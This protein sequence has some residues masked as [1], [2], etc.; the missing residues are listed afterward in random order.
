M[1]TVGIGLALMGLLALVSWTV[2]T[3]TFAQGIPSS[4]LPLS[5]QTTTTAAQEGPGNPLPLSA[6]TIPC[7]MNLPEGDIDGETI[8]CGQIEVPENWD[9]PGERTLVIT[10]AI[11]KANSESPFADPIIFFEGGPGI[12]ALEEIELLVDGMTH[13]RMTRD[14]IYFD[15]RGIR[16]SSALECPP[17]IRSTA[18]EI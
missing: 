12:S 4:P 1:R 2:T 7:P 11:A 5:V 15:Q 6:E 10:Y 14:I 3:T 13:L 16:F 17:E 8:I 9:N 18:N